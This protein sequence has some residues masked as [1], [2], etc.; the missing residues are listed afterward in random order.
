MKRPAVVGL[1]D[2]YFGNRPAVF[3]KEILYAI[4]QG[5]TVLGAASMGALRAAE[6]NRFGMSGIGE[7]Y[8]MFANGEIEG[9]DEVA[10]IH[11]PAELGFYSLTVAMVDFRDLIARAQ[12]ALSIPHAVVLKLTQFAQQLHFSKRSWPRL[13]SFAETL[14]VP[15][16][17]LADFV[18]SSGPMVK[19]R[20]AALLLETVLAKLHEPPDVVARGGPKLQRTSYWKRLQARTLPSSAT[21]S[22]K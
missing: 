5:V 17:V 1:I 16:G 13:F 10:I 19:E 7:V 15:A 18:L 3:H 22:C 8:R 11:T 9:D 6:L 12:P 21:G 2:G 20:D 14:G 4:D